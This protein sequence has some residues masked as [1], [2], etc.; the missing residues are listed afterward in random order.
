MKRPAFVV[1]FIAAGA[2]AHGPP[3]IEGVAP[4][5]SSQSTLWHPSPSVTDAGQRDV[6]G[7]AVSLGT[8]RQ[9]TLP[10]VVDLA[11]RNSPATRASWTQA[12]AAADV[13]GS[14]E[15]R[16]YPTVT[17]GVTANH[18]LTAATPGRAG[19][20]RTQYGPSLN[21]AYTVLDFGGR[22]GTIDVAR[23]TAIAADLTH[24]ATIENTILLVEGSAFSYLST[25]AQRNGQTSTLELA[26]QALDVANERHRV[27]LGTIADVLQAQTA[28]SQ[29]QLELQTLEGALLVARGSLAVAM[30]APANLPFDIPDV[31]ATDSVHFITQ[32]VDSL[33]NMAVRNRPEL[34]TTRAEAAAAASQIRVARSAYLPALALGATGANN[35]SNNSTFSGRTYS[36]NL[37]VQVPVFTGFS[38]QYDVAAAS[39]QYQSALARGESTKQLV[40]QQVFTAYYTL[41][42]STDRVRTS[43]DLLASATQ[44]E[45]VARERYREGV[46]SIVDL[47]VAQ[48][49][50]ANARAQ[51][52]D[53]RWQWRTALAQLA[54]DVGVLNA[55]G[56]TTFASL[57]PAPDVRPDK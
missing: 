45:L 36:F 49:A 18:A 29:A 57:T 8:V 47:L 53:A 5:P 37:G 21:L 20:E 23:Q 12:R 56:D 38:S 16:L 35:G 25:R 27:G 31:A 54:H 10:E 26:T 24:N 34:A 55:R 40:I 32:S 4:T 44:S 41:R 19:I 13:Y 51:E 30:G 11:L 28:R 52:V 6:S 50:L 39:E 14:T 42:T 9:M 17:A 43:R 48:S 33:I 7:A 22:S 46:G 3:K 2:C 15:G 1:A